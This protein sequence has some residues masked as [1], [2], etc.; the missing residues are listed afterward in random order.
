MRSLEYWKKRYVTN[1][2][3]LALISMFL[4][5][6]DGPWGYKADSQYMCFFGVSKSWSTIGGYFFFLFLR[7]SKLFLVVLIEVLYGKNIF[8]RSWFS[9]SYFL[10]HKQHEIILNEIRVI[11]IHSFMAENIKLWI[12]KLIYHRFSQNTNFL[13]VSNGRFGS[14]L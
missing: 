11:K 4:S 7:I 6:Y 2:W 13:P 8:F 1:L 12:I 10:P 14:F 9:Q 3:P 5:Y